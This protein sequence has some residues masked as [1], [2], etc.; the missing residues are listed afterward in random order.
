MEPPKEDGDPIRLRE[1]IEVHLRTGEVMKAAV[2]QGLGRFI[3]TEN[4]VRYNTLYRL[5]EENLVAAQSPLP[6][7]SLNF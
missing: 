5:N 7:M 1:C 6:S 3:M 2:P 4:H